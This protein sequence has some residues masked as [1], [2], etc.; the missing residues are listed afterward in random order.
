MD[1]RQSILSQTEVSLSLAKH[2]IS[3]HAKDKNLAIS[4]L[5]IQILLGIIANG[6]NGPTR[7]QLMGFLKS[8]SIEELNTLSSKLVPY[9]FANGEPLG[10]PRLSFANSV[11]V[12]QSLSFKPAFQEITHNAYRAAANRVDFQNKVVEAIKEVNTWAENETSGLVKEILSASSV[13]A[14]TKLIF[15]N[16]LYFKGTWKEIFVEYLTRDDEFFLLNGSSIQAPFMTNRMRQYA[17]AFDGFKVLR[18]EY[19]QGTRDYKREFSMYFFLPDAKDGLPALLEKV[20]TEPGFIE[21]HKPDRLVLVGEFRIPKF[22]IDFQLEVSEVLKELGVVL[23]FCKGGLTE[24]VGSAI[25]GESLYVSGMFQKTS[26]EVNEKG[27]EALA[28]SRMCGG[29][30]CDVELDFVADHPFLFVIREDR[31]GVVLFIG[32]LLNPLA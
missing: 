18:R 29:G 7:D 24:M 20:C 14:T 25:D 30:C 2:V 31:S 26:I 23:P 3:A 8:K 1:L 17:R 22:R 16:A 15:A 5:S 19:K 27:T 13:D 12:D 32:Q 11:W 6:S 9:V 10:G 4:P 21:S 28:V